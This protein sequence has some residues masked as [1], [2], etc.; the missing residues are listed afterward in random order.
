MKRVFQIISYF[1]NLA[2][3]VRNVIIITVLLIVVLKV[4]DIF[5]DLDDIFGRGCDTELCC[6]DCDTLRVTRIIDGDT[7][8]CRTSAIM[9]H[10]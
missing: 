7:L 9:G 4:G 8:D 5:I 2:R 10:I 1:K 6:E 3:T